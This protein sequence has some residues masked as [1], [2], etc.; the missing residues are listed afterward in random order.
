MSIWASGL[1]V[2]LPP[3]LGVSCHPLVFF[4]C[5]YDTVSAFDKSIYKHLSILKNFKVSGLLNIEE[6]ILSVDRPFL[7]IGAFAFLYLGSK[8]LGCDKLLLLLDYILEFIIS[9]I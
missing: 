6:D 9:A 5:E 8:D 1:R 4:V 2:T 7:H 3:S